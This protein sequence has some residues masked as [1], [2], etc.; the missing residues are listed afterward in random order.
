[1]HACV[2][3]H[4]LQMHMSTLLQTLGE[5]QQSLRESLNSLRKP[6]KQTVADIYTNTIRVRPVPLAVY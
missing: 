2:C 5:I 1:M 4:V 3:A 6:K